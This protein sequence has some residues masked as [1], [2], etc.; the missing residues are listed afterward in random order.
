LAFFK[1][2]L[3]K[4]RGCVLSAGMTTRDSTTGEGQMWTKA[5]HAVYLV[6]AGVATIGW[7]WF[8]GYG[9][10]TLLGY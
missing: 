4:I 9:V 2:K 8:L 3:K 10:L 7:T 6:S 1:I 5:F